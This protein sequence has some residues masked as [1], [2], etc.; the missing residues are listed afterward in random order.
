[1]SDEELGA[2]NDE[3]LEQLALSMSV[4]DPQFRQIWQ[5]YEARH[6]GL[7]AQVLASKDEG[8]N[9]GCQ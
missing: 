1:M 5:A 9:E 4:A 6:T 7:L 8:E 2:L 3:E